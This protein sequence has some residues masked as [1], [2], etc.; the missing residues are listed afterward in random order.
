MAKSM[1][2]WLHYL[3]KYYQVCC[4]FVMNQVN[5]YGFMLRLIC[6]FLGCGLPIQLLLKLL[7]SEYDYRLINHFIIYWFTSWTMKNITFYAWTNTLTHF[8]T[9]N[10][11]IQL[12]LCMNKLLLTSAWQQAEL[13]IKDL[14]IIRAW[15]T[16]CS[17][18]SGSL[19]SA[20][21]AHKI[22]W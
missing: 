2:A 16:S 15:N 12:L 5:W 10:L 17:K 3:L 8:S 6:M 14:E 1:Y 21:H 22:D 19:A 4:C 18:Q 20:A 9:C 13:H 7:S 11:P